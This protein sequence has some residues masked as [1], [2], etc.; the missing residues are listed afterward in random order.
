MR[1]IAGK[2]KSLPLL[3]PRGVSIRPTTDA[4]REW[5]FGSLGPAVA[6]ANFADLYAGSGA[7]GI[8]AL[9]RGARQA[10]FVENNRRCLEGIKDN[11]ENTNLGQQAVVV[12]GQVLR[13]WAQVAAQYGPFDIVFIDPPYQS[14][15][16]PAV[17]NRLI[18][19]A[20][21]MANQGLV[22]VQHERTEPL[23]LPGPPEQIKLFGQTQIDFFYIES[24]AQ[25]E[26]TSE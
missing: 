24:G 18:V 15:D 20:Q 11:L 5:L 2:A 6:G 17:A 10:I 23:M 8:E 9:S 21:G 19:Q 1:V 26:N 16:L 13:R 12:D 25:E 7:V 22:L 3:V 4:M 14:G